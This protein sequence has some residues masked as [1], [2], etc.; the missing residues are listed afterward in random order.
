MSDFKIVDNDPL[1]SALIIGK[2]TYSPSK[3]H[4]MSDDIRAIGAAFWEA[5]KDF[6]PTG[7][8]GTNKN[9]GWDFATITDIYNGVEEALHKQKI[10]IWHFEWVSNGIEYLTTR[11]VHF[12]TGQFVEDTR[13]FIIEKPGNQAKG[14]SNTYI[15]KQAIQSLC[16][17]PC[18]D[19]DCEEE[20][21]HIAIKHTNLNQEPISEE[22]IQ[23]I[24]DMLKTASNHKILYDNILG[25]NKIKLM[26]DL[27]A[28]SFASVMAYIEKNKK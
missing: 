15:R 12:P 27:P 18:E 2:E 14:A 16:A 25:F 1:N 20:Q 7:K 4:S 17:I 22:Q 26:A 8:S 9:Q 23:A 24:K 28:K 5:K 10:I 13:L 19:D 6:K 21:E 3:T 11:L